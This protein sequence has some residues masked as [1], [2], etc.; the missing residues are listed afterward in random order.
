MLGRR[1]QGYFRNGGRR[2]TGPA[3]SP[4]GV[5]PVVTASGPHA[6]IAAGTAAPGD[7]VR[8]NRNR[9]PLPR[10]A[11]DRLRGVPPVLTA[12]LRGPALSPPRRA[13][14]RGLGGSGDAPKAT[15]LGGRP[16]ARPGEP[17][18]PLGGGRS[19]SGTPGGQPGLTA[20]SPVP[21]SRCWRRWNRFCRRKCRA[22]VKSNVFYWL[23]I[24]LVFLNTLTI[25]SEHYNQPHWLT[26]VQ[27]QPAPPCRLGPRPGRGQPP[28]GP[29]GPVT[30]SLDTDVAL[31][32]GHAPPA[33]P[34]GPR[35]AQVT[36]THVG[37]C[38]GSSDP[39][40]SCRLQVQL[41]GTP[42]VRVTGA[43]AGTSRAGA[44]ASPPGPRTGPVS[45]DR[46]GVTHGSP[47]R[48]TSRAFRSH[49]ARAA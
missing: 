11:A 13:Q 25:A 20:L 37:A 14:S 33:C 24:F 21:R 41:E 5:S 42:D 19:R 34:G 1:L 30:A 39:G 35:R 4:R 16:A 15:Q 22:A 29:P 23:V 49:A 28:R 8:S 47:C 40:L 27:G 17:P 10:A 43:E 18:S 48:D 45:R 3:R 7:A 6:T 44:S 46:E 12:P 32:A 2:G 26:E 36:R 38:L 9:C 31:P